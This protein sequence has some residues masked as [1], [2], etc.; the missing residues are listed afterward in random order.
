MSLGHPGLSRYTRT[1][2]PRTPDVFVSLFNNMYSTNFA[3]WSDGSWTSRLRLWV[4]GETESRAEELI[5]N[6][7]EARL[8][9]LAA[10]TDAAPGKLP[11]MAEGLLIERQGGDAGRQHRG[12]LVTAFGRNPYGEGT[13]SR[14]WEQAGS[15]GVYTIRLPRGM[16][17]ENRTALRPARAAVR[18]PSAVSQTGTFEVTIRPMAPLSLIL[19]P[20]HEKM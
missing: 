16:D 17:V 2:T 5:G 18:A 12:L 14:L 8:E 15:G 7:W 6:S 1:F 20:R 9:C 19:L 3:Q 10:V 11:P 13:V 4:P